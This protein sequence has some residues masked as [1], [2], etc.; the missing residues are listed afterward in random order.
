MADEEALETEFENRPEES[1]NE[2]PEEEENNPAA[3]AAPASTVATV[4]NTIDL[5]KV[6]QLGDRVII[7]STAHG[8]VEG[9]VY[10]RSGELIRVKPDGASNQL[11]DFQRL[12]DGRRDEFD[13]LLEVKAAYIITKR[14]FPDFI[15]QQ[16]FEVGQSIT[17]ISENSRMTK[18]MLTKMNMDEDSIV[19]TDTTG[20]ELELKFSHVG[21]DPETDIKILKITAAPKPLQLAETVEEEEEGEEEE[22]EEEEEE[23][24]EKEK[25]ERKKERGRV[26]VRSR[27]ASRPPPLA[28]P[29]PLS[30]STRRLLVGASTTSQLAC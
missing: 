27:R 14:L 8:F 2:E 7:D 4:A 23:G 5:T 19:L 28:A 26:L 20:S 17:A 25:R 13:P 3:A 15:R 1:G 29:R 22:G 21:I 12:Y 18:Y 30:T 6:I 9:T 11:I 16:M 24:E 10:Y